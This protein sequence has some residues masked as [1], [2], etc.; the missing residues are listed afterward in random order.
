MFED[1]AAA[2]EA[3]APLRVS[4]KVEALCALEAMEAQLLKETARA[5]RVW[6]C[7]A[8]GKDTLGAEP[9]ASCREA[10]HELRREARTLHHFKCS[11]CS[12]RLAHPSAMCAVVCPKCSARGP[13]LAASIHNI[14]DGDAT[15]LASAPAQQEEIMSLRFA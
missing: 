12:H 5:A 4:S 13:W 8:C 7:V 2:L 1:A 15:G 11:G 14:R 3:A 6:W 10:G 9:L